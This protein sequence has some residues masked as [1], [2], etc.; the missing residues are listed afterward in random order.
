MMGA[1]SL[2]ELLEA[3]AAYVTLMNGR[4][5]FSRREIFDLFD[6]LNSRDQIS[7]EA[8]IK[9]FS[10]L[11]RSGVIERTQDGSFSMSRSALA[12]YEARATA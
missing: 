11:L 10:R 9:T 1:A 8:R 6:E 4:P 3:S 7:H 12:Q 5:N 2:P